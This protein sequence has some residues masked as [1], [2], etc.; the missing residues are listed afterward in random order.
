MSN[1]SIFADYI[2]DSVRPVKQNS[3]HSRVLL[4]NIFLSLFVYYAI[5]YHFLNF[6]RF[7]LIQIFIYGEKIDSQ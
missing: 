4:K 3:S 6:D 7:I 2:T 5:I 1:F